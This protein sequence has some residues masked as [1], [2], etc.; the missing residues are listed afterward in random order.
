[1]LP[2]ENGQGAEQLPSPTPRYRALRPEGYIQPQPAYTNTHHAH[3]LGESYQVRRNGVMKEKTK[4]DTYKQLQTDH[5]SYITSLLSNGAETEQL[6]NG[7]QLDE[8]DS[9]PNHRKTGQIRIIFTNSN[10]L[11]PQNQNIATEYFIQSCVGAQADIMSA[12]EVNQQL[13]T[14]SVRTDLKQCISNFDK[15]AKVQSGHIDK[16]TSGRKFRMGGQMMIG[17]GGISHFIKNSR[18]DR[19]GRWTWMSLGEARLHVV[20]AYRVQSGIS[21]TN[22][23]CAQENHFLLQTNHPLAKNPRKAFD[24]DFKSFIPDLRQKGYPV[25][26]LIDANSGYNDPEI[27][28]PMADTG[29]INALLHQFPTV[30]PLPT[31]NRGTKAIDMALACVQALTLIKKIGVL[32]FYQL[33]PSDRRTLFIDIYEKMLQALTSDATKTTL[34]VP[35]LLKPS[36]AHAFVTWYKVLLTKACLFE[37]VKEISD[38]LESASQTEKHFLIKR[39]NKYDKAWVE[40]LKSATKQ[41][42]KPAGTKPW[43]PILAKVGGLVRYWNSCIQKYHQTGTLDQNN[44]PFLHDAPPPAVDTIEQALAHR[45]DAVV[46]WHKTKDNAADFRQS[47]PEDRV[48]AYAAKHDIKRESAVKQILHSEEIHTLHNRQ[49]FIMKPADNSQLTSLIIQS[50]SSQDPNAVMEISE[51][52]QILQILLCRNKQKLSAAHN[53]YF[54]YGQLHDTVGE[55]AETQESQR[56]LDGTFELTQVDEWTKYPHKEVFK[57]FLKI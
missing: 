9:W 56:L 11:S 31:Y 42:R 50:P 28:D 41:V 44:I 24:S 48:D 22:T 29:L 30:T 8:H 26:V 51:P 23:I 32:A 12:V 34:N 54:N 47:H 49:W 40:L 38:R 39:L 1:M 52:D 27:L 43:S 55:Y 18:C 2:T 53:G 5:D 15:H 6:T 17:Q 19:C 37:K 3:L 21:G 45:D 16:V 46:K 7:D 14:P 36:T 33:I 13:T 10:G 57:T 25:L 20:C 4:P 35:S